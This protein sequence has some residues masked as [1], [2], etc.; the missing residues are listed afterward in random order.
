VQTLVCGAALSHGGWAQTNASPNCDTIASPAPLATF[1]GPATASRGQ[2]ELGIAVGTYGE[3]S[4]CAHEGAS[5]WLVRLRRGMSDRIDLGFDAEVENDTSGSVG[6][7]FKVAMRYRITKGLR[8]EGGA[9]AAD[10]GFGGRSLNA[11]VAATLGTTNQ[12]KTWNYYTSL[13]L[14]GSRGCINLF[15]AGDSGTDHSP[16]ALIPLGVIGTTAR[17]ADNAHFVLEAGLGNI[18]SREHPDGTYIHFSIG[19]LYDVGKRHK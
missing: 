14:G 5:D 19:V 2:T 4:T 8:L 12:D 7:T 11:D 9:G 17:V 16:G 15:C 13:R 1:G 18:F 10:G 6:G 3:L